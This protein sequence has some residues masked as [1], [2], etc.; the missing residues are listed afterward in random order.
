M[1]HE[2]LYGPTFSLAR[3]LLEPG[4]SILAESGAMVSMSPT[5]T[6]RSQAVGGVGKAIGRLLGGESFFQTTF[7]ATQGA[8]E[9]L[10]APP[11]LGDILALSLNDEGWRVTSG[12]FLAGDTSLRIETMMRAK[13]MFAGEGLFLM[14]ISGSGRLL[15]SCFG[16]IH[17]VQ[18]ALG[19]PY[20]VDTGHIVAFQDTMDYRVRTAT[21]SLLGSWTSGE[22]FAAEFVGPGT[23][24]IQTRAPQSFGPWVGRFIPSKP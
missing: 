11:S 9:L 15:L 10:L 22:G 13:A 5:I 3:L 14:R 7:T 2:I 20:V 8:G 19:Q 16:A 4:D 17:G 18:L 24:Y 6:M 23:I 12:C 21:R 1:N